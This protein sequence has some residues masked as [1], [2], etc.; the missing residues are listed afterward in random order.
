MRT[1]TIGRTTMVA[2]KMDLTWNADHSS[3]TGE[4]LSL[5]CVVPIEP[6]IADDFVLF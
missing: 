2:M 4:T 1:L 5:A 3:A 6:S